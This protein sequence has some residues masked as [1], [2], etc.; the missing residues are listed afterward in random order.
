MFKILEEMFTLLKIFSNFK[1]IRILKKST[2][3]KKMLANLN[4]CSCSK[5]VQNFF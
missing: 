3:L 2:F 4:K 5:N 1:K